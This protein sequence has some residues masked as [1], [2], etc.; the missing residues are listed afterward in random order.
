[1]TPP[2]ERG[3]SVSKTVVF[4]TLRR[5]PCL[6]T[7]G[8]APLTGPEGRLQ[9]KRT[10]QNGWNAEKRSLSRSGRLQSFQNFAAGECHMKRDPRSSVISLSLL[11]IFVVA[12]CSAAKP[13]KFKS[14]IDEGD[15]QRYRQNGTATV[16]G[17]AFMRQK[18][19]GVVTCAGSEVQLAPDVPYVREAIDAAK[20]GYDLSQE[21]VSPVGA[22]AGRKAVC[23]AQ[24]NF[25]FSNLPGAS[26]FLLTQVTWSAG[27]LLQGGT[28]IKQ[29]QTIEGQET[30]VVISNRDFA[31]NI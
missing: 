21:K 18:G 20:K 11:L 31:G 26:W 30:N 5:R 8:R 27:D 12:A 17:S 10:G 24:G 9:H 25:K 28:L 22:G 15:M 23:D 6:P 29:A 13:Y 7:L 16:T 2:T 3:A 19:G 14:T 4:E 1:M